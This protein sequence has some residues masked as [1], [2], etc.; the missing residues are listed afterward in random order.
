VPDRHQVRLTGGVLL[1]QQG[2]RVRAVSAARHCCGSTAA[3]CLA[4]PNPWPCDRRCSDA[5][6]SALPSGP[7]PI[8]HRR[9]PAPARDALPPPRGQGRNRGAERRPV[10][11]S[12]SRWPSFCPFRG[13]RYI[14]QQG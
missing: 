5:R 3:P 6:S 10:A 12:R 14:T 2:D 7:P 4:P 9:R 13:R 8:L 11:L 1:L